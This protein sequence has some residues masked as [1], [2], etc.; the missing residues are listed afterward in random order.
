MKIRRL[1]SIAKAALRVVGAIEPPVSW[2]ARQS[3]GTPMAHEPHASPE[4]A[5]EVHR[6]SPNSLRLRSIG[7][8]IDTRADAL[9]ELQPSTHLLDDVLAL[10][11]RMDNDGYLFLPGFFDGDAVA[12][13]RRQVVE[14]LSAEG[15]LDPRRPIEDA[16]AA[17]HADIQLRAEEGRLP[18]VRALMNSTRMVDFYT[19][20]LGGAVRA[21][22]HIWMR[23]VSPGHGTAAH[24]DLV[25]MGRGTHNLYGSWVPLGDIALEQGA[26]LVLEGS[27]KKG[28]LWQG[29]SRMDIDRDGNWT[30][31]RFRHGRFFRGGDYSRNPRALQKRS[32]LRWLTVDYRAGDVVIMKAQTMH[33]SLDNVSDSIRISADTR[34]QLASEPVDER[35]IGEHPIGH[36]DAI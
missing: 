6:R 12:A 27:H 9:G 2:R 23:M 3:Y 4:G 8:R 19:R 11:Q 21:Y 20:F 18:T 17:A 26:L 14:W 29:Y 15:L 33:A 13:A 5:R 1:R 31:L 16:C 28:H 25:Y 34:Y 36:P 24:L 7:I 32:G 30:K 22:D 35:W 10:R